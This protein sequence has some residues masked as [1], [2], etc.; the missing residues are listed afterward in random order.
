MI[1]RLKSE[2]RAEKGGAVMDIL[3]EHVV[4]ERDMSPSQVA[5]AKVVLDKCVPS[6]Q[7]VEYRLLDAD[8]LSEEEI[9]ERIRAIV[10]E[11]PK[12]LTLGE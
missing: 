3:T 12:L 4:G 7:A 5:A 11:N 8:G 9:I 6:L 10:A 2:D 1:D